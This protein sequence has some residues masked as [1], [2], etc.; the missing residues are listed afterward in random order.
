[1]YVAGKRGAENDPDEDIVEGKLSHQAVLLGLAKGQL[2]DLLSVV[3]EQQFTK[4]PPRYT[5]A[6]LVKA[7]EEHG[8]GRPST[9][10]STLKVLQVS[11]SLYLC[12]CH[13]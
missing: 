11:L 3:P 12:I 2:V 6:S 4:P 5:E 9:Y 13:N 10:A 8:I 7:L 1:M